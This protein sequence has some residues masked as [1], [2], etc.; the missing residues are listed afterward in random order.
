[1]HFHVS[2]WEGIR[3]NFEFS[4]TWNLARKPPT[5]QCLRSKRQL[6]L[7]IGGAT[8]S[9]RHTAR[10]LSKGRGLPHHG[11]LQLAFCIRLML[12]AFWTDL[13]CVPV[14]FRQNGDQPPNLGGCPSGFSSETPA[15]MGTLEETVEQTKGVGEA[16]DWLDSCQW[17]QLRNAHLVFLGPV[18]P[19][20]KCVAEACQSGFAY[21]ISRAGWRHLASCGFGRTPF[22]GPKVKVRH[23][24]C[25]QRRMSG[26]PEPK[27][28]M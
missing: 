7:M 2:W 23:C 11:F 25:F 24:R 27:C 28:G 16:K 14:F 15:R 13:L 17:T 20:G 12:D 1:M 18:G 19:V 22:H 8:T 21:F 10:T 6:P 5:A 26:S 3:F 4:K 9:K